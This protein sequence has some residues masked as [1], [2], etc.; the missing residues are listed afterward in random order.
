MFWKE[1]NGLKSINA[2]S[3]IAISAFVILCGIGYLFGFFN[4]LIAYSPVD[5]EPG[6]SMRDIQ[7]S[8]WGAREK[9]TL[10]A[11]IDGSMKDYFQ[12]EAEY[13]A[14]KDWIASGATEEGFAEIKPIFDVSCSTCH[15]AEA[16]VADVVTVDYGDVETY[17]AQDTGKSVG[18]LVSLSHTHLLATVPLIFLLVFIF[19]FTRWHE[20]I[21]II[22]VS[23][24][25]LAICVDIGSWWL[26]K[27]S[28]AA[29]PLVI[30]GG[31]ALGT[32][33]ALLVLGILYDMWLGKE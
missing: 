8:F 10:E 20:T 33:F 1:S 30:V 21:K 25:F 31:A 4:I 22:L 17:L 13:Q 26:A 14:T 32:S 3:K 5:E 19:A 28:P 27:L 2:S 6:L 15:S 11:S 23:L 18:R 9:T 7:I 29:A 12:S 16:Q 24:S